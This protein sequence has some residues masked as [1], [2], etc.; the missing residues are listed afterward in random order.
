MMKRSLSMG[1]TSLVMLCSVSVASAQSAKAPKVLKPATAS[2]MRATVAH[3]SEALLRA[4]FEADA[5]AR[6]T[7]TR[8]LETAQ[9]TLDAEGKAPCTLRLRA[10][11]AR[12][13][14]AWLAGDDAGAAAMVDA[15]VALRCAGSESGLVAGLDLVERWWRPAL[16]RHFVAGQRTGAKA[17]LA[18]LKRLET[19]KGYEKATRSALGKD[20]PRR[21]GGLLVTAVPRGAPASRAGIRR[22]DVIISV[23]ARPVRRVADIGAHLA[24]RTAERTSVLYYREGQRIEGAWPGSSASQIVGVSLPERLP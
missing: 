19:V 8:Y 24:G 5:R 2:G 13:M 21:G 11:K 17:R 9:R 14:C 7:C 20:Y 15:L 1:L 4:P 3:Y 10:L 18:R 16:V 6:A 23:A 22:G 12:G